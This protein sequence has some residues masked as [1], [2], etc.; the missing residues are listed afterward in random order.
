VARKTGARWRFNGGWGSNRTRPNGDSGRVAVFI[1]LTL[2]LLTGI[3]LG[4]TRRVSGQSESAMSLFGDPAAIPAGLLAEPGYGETIRRR[5]VT[6][7]TELLGE[8]DGGDAQEGQSLLMNL[9]PDIQV[10]ALPLEITSP[11]PGKLTWTGFI[12]GYP[13]ST[14]IL[15]RSDEAL[16]GSIRLDG[17]L[18]LLTY[19]GHDLHLLSELSAYEPFEEHL[20]L[21]V[22]PAGL[23]A[24]RG[25]ATVSRVDIGADDGSTIDVLVVYTPAARNS[26]G[27]TAGIKALIELAIAE[28]NQAYQNSLIH[29][30]LNLVMAAEVNYSESTD[31]ITDLFRLQ[32]KSDGFMDGVHT[33]RDDAHADMVSLIIDD[34][35]YVNKYCGIAYLMT[36]LNPGFESFAFSVINVDCA[37]GYYS[38]SHELGHNMGSAHDRGANPGDSLFDY[39]FGYQAPNQAFRTIMAYNCPNGCQRIQFFSNPDVTY[40]G[41]PT[42]IDY[43]ANPA[44]AADNARSINEARYTVANWRVSEVPLPD[45]PLAPVNLQATAISFSEISLTWQ[46]QANDA[47]G[48]KVERKPNGGSW[49]LVAVLPPSRVTT[50]DRGLVG[51]T[52]Y[53]YRIRAYNLGGNSGYSNVASA[54]TEAAAYQVLFPLFFSD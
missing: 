8:P 16:A 15:V 38:F 51:Q 6:V 27:G 28:S 30:S 25:G 14:V 10:V 1:A 52:E 22:Q 23:E 18:F 49:S 12:P 41:Q 5:P 29:T 37:T 13:G 9:F 40:Q 31:I 46:N 47:D 7:K 39:S 54:Q 26:R 33:W 34:T 17:R 19:A 44:Q 50:T 53:S 48:I 21:P 20:P 24:Q 3:F 2:L 43:E 11:A 32:N 4:G 36:E 42:G 35:N 45:P